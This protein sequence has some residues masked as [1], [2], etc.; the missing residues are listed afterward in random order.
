MRFVGRATEL[1]RLRAEAESARAGA[2]RILVVTGDAGV[3]KTR[4]IEE[5]AAGLDGFRYARASAADDAPALWPWRRALAAIGPEPDVTGAGFAARAEYVATIAAA[6]AAGPLL[7]ALDD[8]HRADAASLALLRELAD[9]APAVPLLVVVA[10]RDDPAAGVPTGPAVTRL[11]LAGVGVEAVAELAAEVTGAPLAEPVVTQLHRRTDG[12]PHLIGE[13]A[14]QFAAAD[15]RAAE[16]G[17]LPVVWPPRVVAAARDRL[18]GLAATTRRVLAGAAVIGREFDLAV[19]E[20]VA[21]SEV[22]VVAALDDAV[23]HR[24]VRPAAGGVYRFARSVDRE[25]LYDGLGVRDRA[26]AHDAVAAALVDL[27]APGSER[28]A[29]VAELAYHLMNAAVLGGADRLDA[30]I[31]Y[32]VSAGV[33]A[34]QQGRAGDAVAYHDAAVHLAARAGWGPDARGR[35]IVAAAVARLANGDLAAGRE[36]LAAAARQGRRAGDRGLLAAAALGF[37]PPVGSGVT[38]PPPDGDLVG[39]LR[40]ALAGDALE[41]STAAR[42]HARLALELAGTE[43][44][45]RHVEAAG[46][47][48]DASGDPRAVAEAL[49]ARAAVG[50][51]EVDLRPA[52]AAARALGD[53]TMEGRARLAIA[54]ARL[55][56]GDVGA[57]TVELTAVADLDGPPV[58]RWSAAVASAHLSLLAGRTDGALARA[59]TARSVGQ[60]V[61]PVGAALAHA[62][63]VACALLAQGRPAELAP[64]LAA[65]DRLGLRP[66]WLAALAGLV[67]AAQGRRAVAESLLA[68][69]LPAADGWTAVLLAD[70]AVE[71]SAVDA[72]R[73]LVEVLE[74]DAGRWIVLGPAVANGGPVAT[75]LARLRRLLGGSAPADGPTSAL[76][77]REREVL[78]LAVT[79]L[80][81]RDI[82]ARL[83]VGERT[84]ETHLANI[85]RKLK[86]RTRVE[87]IARFGPS[88]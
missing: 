78:E 83:Y 9:A 77:R 63:Q 49:L 7:I 11:E 68:E 1:T 87:L 72:A 76:T 79:G 59:E 22:D 25:V 65:L 82:A 71:L 20:A 70:L 85:Y 47:R 61:S 8:A 38:A 53:T 19:V 41:D 69:T 39:L 48:A 81:A 34:T 12:N 21:G 17:P 58:T 32:A 40:D 50:T 54:A 86:V 26:E 5:F 4:L 64:T 46:A 57:A 51:V 13:V 36:G 31:A 66:P 16:L 52:L 73:R 43:D 37:G 35:L 23:R 30:A 3:G 2:S 14:G 33:A 6:G 18:G 44:G 67:A 60:V 28:G 24:V 80:P 27:A 75:P 45:G 42:V 29:T 55:R 56:A 74:P 10:A 88:F 62:V 84:V 15:P